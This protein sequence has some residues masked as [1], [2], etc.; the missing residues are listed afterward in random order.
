MAEQNTSSR[1]ELPRSQENEI[2]GN[3]SNFEATADSFDETNFSLQNWNTNSS[4]PSESSNVTV[5]REGTNG[6]SHRS[7]KNSVHSEAA[8]TITNAQAVLV[9][10]SKIFW[11]L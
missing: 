5:F 9:S 2:N 8:K 3:I 4:L 7:E 1:F 11:L 10:T 6:S